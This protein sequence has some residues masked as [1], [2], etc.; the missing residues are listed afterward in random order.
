M[1]PRFIP[2]RLDVIEDIEDYQPGGYHPISVLLVTPLTM[3]FQGP[4]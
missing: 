2:S 1:A 3:A 4:S